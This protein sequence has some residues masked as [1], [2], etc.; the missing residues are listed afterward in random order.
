MNHWLLLSKAG[1]RL[2]G[3]NLGYEDSAG[4]TYQY[5]STVPNHTRVSEGDLVAIWDDAIGLLGVSYAVSISRREQLPK[6][7]RRCP[8]C[9]ATKFRERSSKAPRFRCDMCGNEFENPIHETIHV[10]EFR[11]RYDVGWIAMEGLLDPPTVRRLST[12]PSSQHSI[13][14][15][16]E[17][18]LSSA[19]VEAD[20]LIEARAQSVLLRDEGRDQKVRATSTSGSITR[21]LLD[22]HGPFCA[23]T[24]IN[25]PLALTGVA[26]RRQSLADA[27][28]RAHLLV[29]RDI[30]LLMDLGIVTFDP[31][32]RQ[33]HFGEPGVVSTVAPV[34][35]GQL[36]VESS[37]EAATLFRDH[38]RQWQVAP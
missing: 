34:S 29:R 22:E 3:G 16:D 18:A 4:S 31:D 24:G 7:R 28:D 13:R 20:A 11:L 27:S 21:H 32:A 6:R 23:F 2:H 10:D 33:V 30:P 17:S 12:E 26:L 5:D 9:N 35:A 37:D 15:L 14:P 38:H 25:S 19:L 1:P 36:T 8:E